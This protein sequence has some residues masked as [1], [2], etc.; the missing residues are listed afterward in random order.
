MLQPQLTQFA[1]HVPVWRCLQPFAAIKPVPAQCLGSAVVLL[2]VL[3]LL[4]LM[5]MLLPCQLP[6][7]PALPQCS[8]W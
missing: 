2:L 1:L 8:A 5:L 4:M 6:Q 3:V 7:V